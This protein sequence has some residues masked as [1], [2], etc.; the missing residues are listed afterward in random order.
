MNGATS[1]EILQLINRDML[2]YATNTARSG[3]QTSLHETTR[4]MP[5]SEATQ[6]LM[7]EYFSQLRER[8]SSLQE[9]LN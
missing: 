2:K 8:N 7:I 5:A 3:T 4:T 1:N 6:K 9:R